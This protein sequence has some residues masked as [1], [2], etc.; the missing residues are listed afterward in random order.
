MDVLALCIDLRLDINFIF[1]Y[2]W[3]LCVYVYE[4][5]LIVFLVDFVVWKTVCKLKSGVIL[6]LKKVIF[7]G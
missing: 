1:V 5:W 2:E 6:N 4:T 7:D 3:F